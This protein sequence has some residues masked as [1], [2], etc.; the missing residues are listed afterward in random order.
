[1]EN[2]RQ[3]YIEALSVPGILGLVIGT[4]PDSVDDDKLAMLAE[5]ARDYY[6]AV[7]YGIES[8]YNATLERINR[9]HTFEESVSALQMTDR[10][11]L[12]SG[13]HFIFGLPGET[14][15]QMLD[16]APV[17]SSLPLTTVKFHQLQII[18]G[19]AMA[20][21]YNSSPGSFTLFNWEEYREFFISF[22]ELLSPSLVVER[23]TSEAPP[24]LISSPRWGKKRSE[25]LMAEFEQL[26]EERDTWQGR[27]YGAD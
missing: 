14:R 15:Q 6:I 1:M 7:E 26:L 12:H 24:S 22:L 3:S 2:L 8:V 4:R 9:G 19:T 23:F 16:M 10:Y 5:L 13:A 20:E 25:G 27:R 11:K 21:E 18:R 17:I